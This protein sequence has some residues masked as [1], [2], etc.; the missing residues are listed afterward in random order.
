MNN[1]PRVRIFSLQVKMAQLRRNHQSLKSKVAEELKRP[2][3]CSF[4]LQKLK[5]QRLRI[6]DELERCASLIKNANTRAMSSQQS[7]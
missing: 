3:P 6:K 1:S 2:V 5:R 7:V 4:A